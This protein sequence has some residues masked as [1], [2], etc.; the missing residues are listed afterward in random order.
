MN[1][2]KQ[3]RQLSGVFY[4]IV[5]GTVF[6]AHPATAQ[7]VSIT[8]ADDGSLATRSIQLLVLVPTS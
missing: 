5:V 2:L 3:N 8:L 7:D 4:L 1:P 6:L